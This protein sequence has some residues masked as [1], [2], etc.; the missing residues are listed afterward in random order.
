MAITLAGLEIEKQAVIGVQR[1]SNNQTH[2]NVLSERM[3]SLFISVVSGACM[4]LNQADSLQ[5]PKHSGVC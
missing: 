2:W 3:G 4:T 1:D 5:K